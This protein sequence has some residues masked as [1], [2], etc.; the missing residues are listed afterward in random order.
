MTALQCFPAGPAWHVL[1]V[2]PQGE[3]K[4]RNAVAVAGSDVDETSCTWPSRFD[5]FMPIEM[6]MRT[7]RG[8]RVEVERPLF[9]RYLFVAFDPLASDEWMDLLQ[10]DGVEDVLGSQNELP[11]RVPDAWIDALRRAEHAGA[12]DRRPDASPFK[13]GEMVRIA[14]GPFT[15][16]HARIEQLIAKLKSATATKRVKVL[17]DFL[18]RSS[19]FELPVSAIEK[20]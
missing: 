4:V 17:M 16:L 18:G 2:E 3:R 13:I 14:E 8:K 20:V 10:I 5:V 12:F 7:T 11:S 1:Y 9:S 15:G 19:T 6:S